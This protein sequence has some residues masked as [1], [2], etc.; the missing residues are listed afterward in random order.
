MDNVHKE[1]NTMNKLD[2]SRFIDDKPEMVDNIKGDPFIEKML[3]LTDV[4]STVKFLTTRKG[5]AILMEHLLPIISDERYSSN[6]TMETFGDVR[7]SGNF[8]LYIVRNLKWDRE[9]MPVLC[10]VIDTMIELKEEKVPFHVMRTTEHRGVVEDA[11]NDPDSVLPAMWAETS[12]LVDRPEFYA[13]EGASEKQ[14]I[15]DLVCKLFELAESDSTDLLKG[16]DLVRIDYSGSENSAYL[17]YANGRR[18]IVEFE[19]TDKK[20]MLVHLVNAIAEADD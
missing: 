15:C 16:S 19:D 14:V 1:V 2:K 4:I 7:K 18:K 3:E 6:N 12:I 5:Y 10:P 11:M 17:Q 9:T 13:A 20:E 8:V